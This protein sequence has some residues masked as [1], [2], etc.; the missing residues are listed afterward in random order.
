MNPNYTHILVT[1]E[2]YTELM[3]QLATALERGQESLARMD[4]ANFEQLTAEQETL[5]RQLKS[6]QRSSACETGA[7]P[8]G[9][10]SDGL[11]KIEFSRQRE[12]L[13]RRLSEIEL[14]VRHLNRVN[15]FF[16]NRARQ[17]FELLLRLAMPAPAT[18]SLPPAVADGNARAGKDYINV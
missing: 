8:T 14:R 2:R 7:R 1:M 15:Q 17:S 11:E 6:L 9:L 13:G 5:C 3:R 18:Y 12:V 10:G 16:L 4:L